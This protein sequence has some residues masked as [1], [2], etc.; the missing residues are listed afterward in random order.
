MRLLA[1]E[2]SRAL[3][4]LAP[5]V[6]ASL[7]DRELQMLFPLLTS[8]ATDSVG[9]MATTGRPERLSGWLFQSATDAGGARDCKR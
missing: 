7:M 5:S 1:T 6:L 2:T 3:R 9:G 4:K 8:P